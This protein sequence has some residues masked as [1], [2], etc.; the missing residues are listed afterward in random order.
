VGFPIHLGAGETARKR[1]IETDLCGGALTS[2]PKEQAVG[3]SWNWG[4]DARGQYSPRGF[5]SIPHQAAT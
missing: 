1:E 3:A 2:L 4:H 5:R